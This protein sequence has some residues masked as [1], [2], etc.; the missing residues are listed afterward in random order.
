MAAQ[1][2]ISS[3]ELQELE[4]LRIEANK[5]LGK[6]GALRNN[7]DKVFKGFVIFV[8]QDGSMI[9]RVKF[10]LDMDKVSRPAATSETPTGSKASPSIIEAVKILRSRLS[11]DS[12]QNRRVESLVKKMSLLD[13]IEKQS[14]AR[15]ITV[16]YSRAILF[17]QSIGL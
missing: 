11:D 3:Q 17:P 1:H 6:T 15:N 9:Y 16:V 7:V 13:D 5:L 2:G 12:L 10:T 4:R 8:H 14:P